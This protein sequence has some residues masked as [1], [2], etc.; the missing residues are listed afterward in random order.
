MIGGGLA[1]SEAAWQAARRGLRV[2]LVEM[3]PAVRTPAHR[4]DRLAELV[5]SNSFRGE[6]L[7]NAV[8]L[9]KEELRRAGSIIM[10]AADRWRVPAGGALAVD[11]ER[12][13]AEVTRRLGGLERIEIVRG[14]AAD[15][16]PGVLTIVATGPLTSEAMARFL[17]ERTGSDQLYFYDAIAPIVDA[18]TIDPS[19]VYRA[20]RYGR[21]GADYLNCPLTEEE[22]DRFY[23]A[24]VAA[25]TVP[26]RAFEEEKV[27]E[28]CMPIEVMAARGRETPL[29][30]PMKPVGLPDPRTGREPFA[31]VQLRMEN[32]HATA[33]NL[34]GFQT[35]LKW[36]EQ[37]RVFRMIPGLERAAFLRYGSL[38]RNTYL[39]SPRILDAALRLRG[40]PRLLLA[41]QITGVEGYVESTAMGLLA[42]LNAARMAAGEAPLTPPEETA[43][44]AL[45]GHITRSDPA[46]FQP[47]NVNFGLFPPLGKRI[48]RKR[49]RY[50]ALSARALLRW[51]AFLAAAGRADGTAGR[52][53]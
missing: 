14:E 21:G 42:G 13:A 34:V 16:D 50:E 24:L 43:H 52:V 32:R 38:H 10:S 39:C 22:Y 3:R 23:R 37:E 4:S 17:M 36:P 2:R 15:V 18:E 49:E 7:H 8:G 5:C 35:R 47:S 45:V 30:G 40:E 6:G 25:E 28:G 31:V 9:L 27:F 1:G 19:R 44:G 33:Y 48:R 53:E 20:S 51:D 26:V 41:G 12:F 11:R 29:F 46:R